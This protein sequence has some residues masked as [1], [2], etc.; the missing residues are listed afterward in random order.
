MCK[1]AIITRTKNRQLLLKRAIFS[2]AQQIYDNYIHIIINDGGS[3]LNIDE[4]TKLIPSTRRNKITL[5]QSES[6]NG[7]EAA[8]NWAIKQSH[9]ELIAFLDDDDSWD[10]NFLAI[11]VR[12]LEKNESVTGV[13]TAS[14]IVFEEISGNEVCILHTR[15]YRPELKAIS[16]YQMTQRNTILNHSF[17]Y[18]RAVLDIIGLYNEAMPVLGDWDFNLRFLIKFDIH[19]I[20]QTLAYYHIRKGGPQYGN[21][22]TNNIETHIEVRNKINN[23]LLRDDLSKQ[24]L[25]LGFLVNA[26]L[27]I[28]RSTVSQKLGTFFQNLFDSSYLVYLWRKYLPTN[29]TRKLRKKFIF[30][31][32]F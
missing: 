15:K 31:K 21:T 29:E 3:F 9:S 1:V 2:V 6:S 32:N 30:L 12:Y 7:M 22:I 24:N 5:I 28:Q 10:E 13:S 27:D 8:S 19:F 4:I 26:S 18:R 17:V 23:K 25:G 14:K 16:L 11:T 20:N